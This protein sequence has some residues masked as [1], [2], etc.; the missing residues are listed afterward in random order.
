MKKKNT[1]AVALGA[2]GGAATKNNLTP[3]QRKASAMKAA[4]AA[5]KVHRQKARQ[6]RLLNK[7]QA[8]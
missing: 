2:L 1:A 8:V 6:R 7:Q 5:A 4:R 3:E